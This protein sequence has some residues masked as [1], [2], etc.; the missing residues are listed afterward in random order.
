MARGVQ[1]CSGMQLSARVPMSVAAAAVVVLNLADAVFTLLYVHTGLAR[2]GN[3]MMASALGGGS[4]IF[5]IT[6]L[7]LVSL[8]V[9]L[10]VRLWPRRAA[11]AGMFAAVTVY[12]TLFVYHLS[13][14]PE[15]VS[16]A[17]S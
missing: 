6:K 7:A 1:P 10:L 17:A 13:G 16:V 14:V 15:L 5:M 9:L 8:G 2:E 4:V 11:A 3:P 12:A